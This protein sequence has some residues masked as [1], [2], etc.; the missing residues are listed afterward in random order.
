MVSLI[1]I[2]ELEER[3]GEER[4]GEEPSLLNAGNYT[5][6]KISHRLDSCPEL[7]PVIPAKD[8][9]VSPLLLHPSRRMTTRFRSTDKA[10]S[11]RLPVL[12]QEYPRSGRAIPSQAITN[13]LRCIAS[14]KHGPAI[15]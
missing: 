14:Y 7:S 11:S 3:R 2:S 8:L 1:D 13:R 15:V 4:R 6:T 9:L 10:Q 5:S 12:T